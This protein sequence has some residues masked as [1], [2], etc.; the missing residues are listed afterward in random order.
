MSDEKPIKLL[1]VDDEVKFLE[2]LAQ[3][4][5]LRDFAVTTATDGQKAIKAAKGDKFDVAVVD[6]RMPGM[7]GT[8]VLKTLKKRHKWLEVIILTGYGTIDSAAECTRLGAFGYI[9]KPY[10]IDKLIDVLKQA[11]TE[12]L[13]KKFKHDQKRMEDIEFLSMG[14]SPV[15]ILASLRRLD[16]DEK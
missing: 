2:S 13:K 5:S 7:D 15:S 6:L 1:L 16:D 3:R 11:Y 12:R 4:L 14:A 9:E 8:E 10:D